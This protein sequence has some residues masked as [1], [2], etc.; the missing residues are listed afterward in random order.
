M[1]N[2]LIAALIE[3]ADAD[4]RVF[5]LTADLGFTVVERFAERHPRRFV[6]V[7]VA[8]QNMIGIATGLAQTGFVPFCYSI[9]TFTS[10]RGYEQIRNGPVLHGL[11]V[12]LVGVGG[13]FAYGHAG[14]TH[15]ALED[16][17]ILRAQP[18]MTVV[19]PA[20]PLQT[21]AAVKATHSLPGPVYFRVGKGGN[22]DVS[23]LGGRFA[24]DRPE[25][26]REGR[27]VLF[28]ATGEIVHEAIGAAD[29][30]EEDGISA[31]VAIQAH[32]GWRAGAGLVDLLRR[33]P[34]AVSVEEAYRTGGLGALVA[35]A[36]ASEGLACRLAVRAVES[37]FDGR[38][39]GPGYM[40]KRSG[41]DAASL[42]GAAAALLTSCGRR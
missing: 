38:S 41:L 9:A 26:V 17:S 8:E 32:V 36:I 10:M 11:P 2:A 7:G 30:L 34:A 12:R 5:L 3:L 4:D 37:G 20:D 21:R 13:G 24:L 25:M 35:D 33:Y 23:G 27:D 40:K 1:R 42:A 18:G 19:A 16:L 31:A 22:K 29:R 39:G 14:P 28:V 15:H 6:N